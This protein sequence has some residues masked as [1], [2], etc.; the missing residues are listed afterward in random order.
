MTISNPAGNLNR[1]VAALLAGGFLLLIVNP[2]FAGGHPRSQV[3]FEAGFVQPYGDLADDF[4]TTEKGLG[5][6]S[7]LELGFRWRYRFSESLSIS[8][9]FH[10]IDYKNYSGE[11]EEIGAYRIKPTTLNYSL[12]FMYILL[13]P[14]KAVRPYLAVN[15]GVC[16][17]RL[18]AYWK[19]WDKAFDSSVNTLGVGARAGLLIG[20]FEFSAVYNFNRFDTWRFFNTGYEE[21][22]VWDNLVF[23]AGWIIPFGE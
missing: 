5:I 11:N 1:I 22:Y 10:F 12:E 9:G 7:G 3:V 14:G 6:K 23:R 2:V 21:N 20:G 13:D 15:A 19:T 17:N 4:L 18:E 8:P 16:R